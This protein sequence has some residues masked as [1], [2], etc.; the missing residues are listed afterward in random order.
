MN[1]PAAS[2]GDI[3]HWLKAAIACRARGD[4]KG[5]EEAITRALSLDP[6]DLLALMLRADLLERQ[7]RR[8][9]AAVAYSAVVTVAPPIERLHPDLQPALARAMAFREAYGG[10]FGAFLE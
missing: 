6:M 1:R 5:E 4:A 10:E 2:P 8:H 3:Q 7:G 9:E